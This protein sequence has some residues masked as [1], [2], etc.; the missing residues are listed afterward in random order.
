[1]GMNRS[2]R[3]LP[4]GP[5]TTPHAS[6]GWSR[7][8]CATISSTRSARITSTSPGYVAPLPARTSRRGG[9][10]RSTSGEPLLQA[11]QPA[12]EHPAGEERGELGLVGRLRVVLRP[13]LAERL[14]RVGDDRE[15]EGRDVAPY[16]EGAL[17]DLVGADAVGVVQ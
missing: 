12:G 8:A 14:T 5:A 16:R 1:M 3:S 13:P 4:S 15:R 6:S 10:T 2:G 7:R 9:E 17:E 11:R